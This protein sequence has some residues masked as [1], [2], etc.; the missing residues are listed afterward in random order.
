MTLLPSLRE[1][2]KPSHGWGRQGHHAVGRDYTRAGLDS[3]TL[4]AITFLPRL[5]Q[6]GSQC[7]GCA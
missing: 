1:D 4:L 3:V 7:L 2:F 5:P 6:E